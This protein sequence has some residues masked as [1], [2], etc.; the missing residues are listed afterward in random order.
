M[1][2]TSLMYKIVGV[3]KPP[4]SWTVIRREDEKVVWSGK[5]FMGARTA[6]VMLERGYDYRTARRMG[7]A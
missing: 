3:G 7:N 5:T 4:T 1:K 2:T 6:H